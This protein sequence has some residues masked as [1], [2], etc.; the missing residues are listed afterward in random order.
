LLRRP[1]LSG[2]VCVGEDVGAMAA[3]LTIWGMYP[4]FAARPSPFA[5][6][7]LQL[8]FCTFVHS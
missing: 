8:I 5:Y 1:S 2:T 6:A 7:L 3:H 4:P